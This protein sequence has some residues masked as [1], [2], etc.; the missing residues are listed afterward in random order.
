MR[1]V[2]LCRE[3]PARAHDSIENRSL[4][5]VVAR[6]GEDTRIFDSIQARLVGRR[7]TVPSAGSGKPGN[8]VHYRAAAG[9]RTFGYNWCGSPQCSLT[10]RTLPAAASR[11]QLDKACNPAKRHGA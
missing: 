10:Q 1:R 6:T 9:H 8:A 4:L 3:E 2:V 11:K 5:N 7:D